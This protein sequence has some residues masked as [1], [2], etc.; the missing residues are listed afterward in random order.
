MKRSGKRRL[1]G[2]QTTLVAVLVLVALVL[3]LLVAKAEQIVLGAEAFIDMAQGPWVFELPPND[4]RYMVMPFMDAWTNVFASPG[5]R[6]SGARGGRFLL[7]GPAWQ[8]SVPAG[9]EL[10][11]APTRMV[12]LIGRIQTRGAADYPADAPMLTKLQRLGVAPGQKPR[13]GLADRWAVALGR[14]IADRSVAREL[15][16]RPHRHGWITPP[17]ILGNYGTAYN[18]RAVVAM[19]GLGANLPDDAIYPDGSLDL[20]VQADAPP[21]GRSNWLPVQAGAPFQLTMRLYG[22]RPDALDGKWTPPPVVR[23]D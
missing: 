14:A 8:G 5:T 12:W 15:G 19:V 22:P 20:L 2:L 4:L 21:L 3:A 17:A 6:T 23:V 9:M 1:T 16:K 7:A 10:L 11:R 13:W 18:I